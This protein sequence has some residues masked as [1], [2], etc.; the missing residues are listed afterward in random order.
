MSHNH[1]AWVAP[2]AQ[3]LK[4]GQTLPAAQSPHW[5]WQVKTGMLLL[6]RGPHPNDTGLQ[7]ALPGD[8]L[9]MDELCGLPAPAHTTALV[10]SVL[11]PV[12][13]DSLPLQA[14]LIR[15][16]MRQHQQ[17]ADNLLALRTGPMERRLTHLLTLLSRAS[18]RNWLNQ[19]DRVLPALRDTA[20]LVDASPETA[21]RVLA[22]LRPN[23]PPAMGGLGAG[24]AFA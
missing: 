3:H 12:P 2:S 15:R 8:L 17:S 7:L 1:P 21:C 14:P 18:G 11:E 9:G 6:E 19:A 4:R 23:T 22:R 13:A 24:L 16:L 5:M 10:P 20:R